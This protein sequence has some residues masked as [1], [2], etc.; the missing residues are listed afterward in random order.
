VARHRPAA[1]LTTACGLGALAAGWLLPDE[2]NA[3]PADAGRTAAVSPPTRLRG[4]HGLEA[5][6]VPVAAHR[7]GSLALPDDPRTG[8]WWALGAAAGAADGTLLIAGHVDTREDGLGPFAALHRTPP[9][10]RV[11]VTGADGRVRAYR[12]TARRTYRQERLPADLFAGA[13]GHRLALVTCARP[14][15]RETG[16]YRRN[17]VVYATPVAPTPAG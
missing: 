9:G 11:E 17:L 1:V 16:R 15:D 12:V 8:G 7:D 13:G 3:R 4:P 5:A 2:P 10:A 14:Y 6:V